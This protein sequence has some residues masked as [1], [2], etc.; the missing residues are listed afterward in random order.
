MIT[1]KGT[2]KR[3]IRY[4]NPLIVFYTNCFY[5]QINRSRLTS[6]FNKEQQKKKKRKRKKKEK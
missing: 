1:E 2:A 3:E 5:K 4:L 6:F